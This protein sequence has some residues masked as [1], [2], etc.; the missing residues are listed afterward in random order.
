[1]LTDDEIKRTISGLSSRQYGNIRTI[2][3]GEGLT[4]KKLDKYV[5]QV[6]IDRINLALSFYNSAKKLE[7]ND[8]D[9]LS[10]ISRCY[11]CYYHLAR[12][13]VFLI[14]KNDINDHD[15]LPNMLRRVMKTEDKWLADKLDDWR[16]IRNEVEYSPYPQIE[17][18]VTK[19]ASQMLRSTR[20]LSKLLEGYF[21][22]RGIDNDEIQF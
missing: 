7:I 10:I 13:L 14:T 20:T 16:G 2:C 1:M 9:S 19:T 12:A 3:G 21:K 8:E 17:N 22:E 6:T 5:E 11:Y 18:A 4:K 15:K